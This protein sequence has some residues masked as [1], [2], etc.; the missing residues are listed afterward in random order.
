[1]IPKID[2]PHGIQDGRTVWTN[3][4]LAATVGCHIELVVGSHAAIGGE[5]ATVIG[6]FGAKIILILQTSEGGAGDNV[7]GKGHVASVGTE[8][9]AGLQESGTVQRKS[10]GSELEMDGMKLRD[11]F[12]MATTNLKSDNACQ[13][14]LKDEK[15]QLDHDIVVGVCLVVSRLRQWWLAMQE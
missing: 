1:M 13:K 5:I 4:A 15:E 9:A 2:F 11:D 8:R 7:V 10:E 12:Q 14:E 3:G 6:N